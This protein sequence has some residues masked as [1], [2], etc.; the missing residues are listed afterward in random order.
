MYSILNFSNENRQSKVGSFEHSVLIF[1]KEQEVLRLDLQSY[2]TIHF[3]HTF[4]LQ[5][6]WTV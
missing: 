3:H 6:E 4:P 1:T 5:D 2:R